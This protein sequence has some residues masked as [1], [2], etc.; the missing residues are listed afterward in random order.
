MLRGGF[1]FGNSLWQ[2]FRIIYLPSVF[3]LYCVGLRGP[4]D[5]RALGIALL[6]AALLRALMAAYVRLKFP[7]L[8]EVPHA[9]VHADSMLFA[10]AFVMVVMIFF[11]RPNRRNLLLAAL[12][13]P[14]IIWGM[15][16][17]NRRLAWVE[18]SVALIVMY[19]VTPM[20]RL[21]RRL[22]Q[23]IV[24]SLPVIAIYIAVGWNHPTGVFGP[25]KIARSV[26][27]SK[28]D[29]STLWRDLENYNLYYTLRQNPLVGVGLGH[30][31]I[32]QIHLP[33]ISDAYKLYLYAP[34]NSILG[35]L[36][37][38]GMLGFAGI[39]M[40]LPIGV[41]FS[42]LNYRYARTPQERTAALTC[43]GILITYMAHCYGDMGLGTWN[44]V[45]TVGA[46]LALTGKQAV[47]C[48]AWPMMSRMQAPRPRPVVVVTT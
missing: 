13:L 8:E 39:W 40:I 12:T 22:A 5:T 15:I 20:T 16:A 43:V 2:I 26:I 18:L 41:F 27:D 45:F 17:N 35:L 6:A 47:A 37:Y 30:E 1:S 48:G 24:I 28:S 19:F 33:T 10:N 32:E 4:K 11:E 42:M 31:Y 23:S 29:S 21:K 9:T 7:D 34:H 14:I 46:A 3:L 38:G 36:A 44:S 25:V